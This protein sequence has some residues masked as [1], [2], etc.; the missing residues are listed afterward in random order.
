VFAMVFALFFGIAFTFY[1][2]VAAYGLAAVSM[3]VLVRRLLTAPV[4]QS[5]VEMDGEPLD[6]EP[7]TAGAA[8]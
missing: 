8:S 5:S 3:F 1:A 6:A 2:G 4:V 7:V